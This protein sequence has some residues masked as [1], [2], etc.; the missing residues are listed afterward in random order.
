MKVSSPE[1]DSASKSK[2]GTYR[3][4]SDDAPEQ[5][6]IHPRGTERR[7]NSAWSQDKA[8]QLKPNAMKKLCSHIFSRLPE[9]LIVALVA[10]I[11]VVPTLGSWCALAPDSISYLTTARTLIE[12]GQFPDCFLMRPPGFPVLLAPLFLM[13]D[14]PFLGIRILLAFCF[15][16]TGALTTRLFARELGRGWSIVAGTLVALNG[17]LLVQS[18]IALSELLF[19]PLQIIPFILLDRARGAT[20]LQ[21]TPCIFAALITS[22][23]IMTRSLGILL[24]PFGAAM[25][26]C[27]RNECRRNRAIAATLFCIT[28]LLLPGLWSI[29]QA[30]YPNGRGYGSMWTHAMESEKTDATGFTL[31]TERLAKFGP[32]RL[33]GIKAAIVPNIL[34]WRAFQSSWATAATWGIGLVCLA[35]AAVRLF[36]FKSAVD[37]YLL[38]TLGVLALWPWDEGVRLIIPLL[39]FLVGGLVWALREIY[40]RVDGFKRLAITAVTALGVLGSAVEVGLLLH[41]LPQR[42]EKSQQLFTAMSDM[43]ATLDRVA[44][45]GAPILCV[46][47]NGHNLKLT[48]AGGAFLS[49]R[50]HIEYLDVITK[51]PDR[52]PI[53]G[54]EFVILESSLRTSEIAEKWGISPVLWNPQLSIYG[55]TSMANRSTTKNR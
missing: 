26:Y 24:V 1:F 10:T 50:A 22:A 34:G 54:N 9:W 32:L 4:W 13:S 14:L 21:K 55:P 43:A 7:D 47:P 39:P 27:A 28:A 6:E 49:H 8:V 12:T 23:A 29:R 19:I 51:L 53:D 52:P 18:S 40:R 11:A 35:I 33:E 3:D 2:I 42:S 25:I 20:R 41:R 36:R 16:A 5:S 15:V 48:V 38:A 30:A 45:K 37:G 31:Q 44:P 46:T 17:A